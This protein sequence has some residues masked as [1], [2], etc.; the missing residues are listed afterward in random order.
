VMELELLHSVESKTNTKS[1]FCENEKNDI[2][3]KCRID[4]IFIKWMKEK[5]HLWWRPEVVAEVVAEVE[6][7]VQQM[8][9]Y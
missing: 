8:D 9:S 7:E 1:R 2:I 4:N 6:E 5:I 3:W